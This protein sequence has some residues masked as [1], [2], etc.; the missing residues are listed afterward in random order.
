MRVQKFW[1]AFH[2]NYFTY[3]IFYLVLLKNILGSNADT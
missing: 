3:I 2:R 1:S